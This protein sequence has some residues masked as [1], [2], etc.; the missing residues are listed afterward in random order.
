VGVVIVH[1]HQKNK[2]RTSSSLSLSHTHTHNTYTLVHPQVVV[3]ELTDAQDLRAVVS[4]GLE[5]VASLSSP[6][7]STGD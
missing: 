5:G 4:K 2:I 6:S 7:S 1:C 3:A